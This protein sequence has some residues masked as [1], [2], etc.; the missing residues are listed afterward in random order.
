MD[1]RLFDLGSPDKRS[2]LVNEVHKSKDTTKVVETKKI[3]L[4]KLKNYNVDPE[5]LAHAE[6]QFRFQLPR[7][8]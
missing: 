4:K 8:E 3:Y 2:P 7:N 6:K 5:Y 1:S